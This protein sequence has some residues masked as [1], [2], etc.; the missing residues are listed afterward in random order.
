MKSPSR[1]YTVSTRVMTSLLRRLWINYPKTDP[2]S[3]EDLLVDQIAKELTQTK[4]VFL[5]EYS[6]SNVAHAS[7][8]AFKD[9]YNRIMGLLDP[10][11]PFLE[12]PSLRHTENLGPC[13]IYTDFG[14][15]APPFKEIF[16]SSLSLLGGTTITVD[17][18]DQLWKPEQ[19]Y[20]AL[21]AFNSDQ[22]QKQRE[23]KILSKIKQ[24]LAITQFKSVSFPEEDYTQYL[25]ARNLV[26]GASRRLLDILRSSFNYLV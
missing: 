17:N 22:Y 1:I 25:R 21:Q 4:R 12:S 6:N 19:D 26:Q 15:N 18:I 20:E 13:S 14:L 11:G 23:E 10:L 16:A 5:E 3:E 7:K 2:T 8:M 24:Y 9:N